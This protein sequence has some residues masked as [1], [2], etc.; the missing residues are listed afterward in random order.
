MD[1]DD[2]IGAKVQGVTPAFIAKAKSYG[3]KDLTLEQII[4]LKQSGVLDKQ[5]EK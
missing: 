1:I 3:F 5:A 2:A 4:R